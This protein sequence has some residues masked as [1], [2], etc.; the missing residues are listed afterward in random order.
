MAL[1]GE[2]TRDLDEKKYVPTNFL[3][4]TI[5]DEV[6]ALHIKKDKW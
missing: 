6:V 4:D 2:G 1:I 5:K 3:S